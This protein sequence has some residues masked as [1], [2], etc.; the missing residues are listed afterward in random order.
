MDV[1][2]SSQ[3]GD[4]ALRGESLAIILSC[5]IHWWTWLYHTKGQLQSQ[6]GD[7]LQFFDYIWRIGGRVCAIPRCRYGPKEGITFILYHVLFID[8]C[9]YVRTRGI[10]IYLRWYYLAIIFN[11]NAFITWCMWVCPPKGKIWT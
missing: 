4:M 3:G 9:I 5:L 7:P 11:N 2:V 6:G 10:Y 8:G 1:V